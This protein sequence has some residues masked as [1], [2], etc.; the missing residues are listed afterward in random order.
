MSESD[1]ELQV[2]CPVCDNPKS[3]LGKV[4]EGVSVFRCRKCKR[5]YR[6]E[7]VQ[8]CRSEVVVEPVKKP[9]AA[10]AASV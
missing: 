5:E 6:A 1:K 3:Y 7:V 2:W 8:I 10:E 4:I 9:L